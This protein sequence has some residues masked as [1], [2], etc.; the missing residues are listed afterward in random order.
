MPARRLRL[1]PE[2]LT[3]LKRVASLRPAPVWLVGGAIRDA[4]LGVA[5]GDLD[6]ACSDARGL[7][8]LVA[9]TWKGSLVPLD[10]QN[11]VYRVVP[12]PGTFKTLTQI[13]IAEIQGGSIEKDLER[14]DFTLNAVALPL[15][16]KLVAEPAPS[17]WLDPR[18]GLADA[19]AGV[20]RASGEAPFKED[21]L[22]LLRAF[23]IAA[24]FGLTIEEGTLR[25][26][27]RQRQ[28]IRRPAPERIQAELTALLAVPGASDWL[29]R[30]DE[31]E[32]L[33]TLFEELEPA[34]RCAEVYYGPGGVLKH[35]LEVC[36][37]LDFLLDRFAEVYPALAKPFAAHMA[38]RS[39]PGAP[40]RAT[41]MLGALLH[42]VAKPETAKRVGGR[43]RFFEHDTIG[44]ARATDILKRLR[45]SRERMD[46]VAALV[47]HHL[48]PGHLAA[49][50]GVTEKAAYRF[51]RD[52]GPD[53]PG[54]LAVCWADHASHL[55]EPRLKKLL[56]A[57]ASPK[58]LAEDARLPEDARKTVAHLQLV[59]DLLRRYFD[60][61]RA[62]LPEPVVDGRDAMKVLKIP[63]GPRVGEALEKVREAQAEGK[64]S[65]R[66]DALAYLAKLK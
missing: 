13:D 63:P 32:L 44:A 11:G 9:K 31:C 14:R 43:L 26:I 55:P 33:T 8:M 58:P 46:C 23:R 62:A 24:Q 52:L 2:A 4:A 17:A 3:V 41:L 57:A 39:A 61:D 22:R 10:E 28:L 42:D 56:K 34:R 59:S 50:G 16:D 60:Q 37:R 29:M 49:A 15:S 19:A 51:F 1:A 27:R 12:A 7:A 54:L 20:L 64:I 21:P 66:A 53:A 47:R 30:L 65:T 36:A 5:A 40:H 48:R 25:A 35:S 6:L 18:G 45:F 38:E